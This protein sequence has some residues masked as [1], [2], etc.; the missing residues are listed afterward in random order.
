MFTSMVAV[1]RALSGAP[2]FPI[3][4]S[5]NLLHSRHPTFS[6]NKR[7]LAFPV[8]HLIEMARGVVEK[9]LYKLEA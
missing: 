8:V 7:D 2:D 9:S 5:A 4:R 6:G 3:G 1:R